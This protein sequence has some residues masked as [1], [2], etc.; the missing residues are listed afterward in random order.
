[1]K[2][3]TTFKSIDNVV[4]RGKRVKCDHL[5]INAI[6]DR[7]A[8]IEDDCQYMIRIKPLDKMKKVV[9]SVDLIGRHSRV[10]RSWRC[11]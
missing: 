1:M 11:Y 7:L 8:D 2:N 3:T 9:R 4:F 5:I 6:E 10:A